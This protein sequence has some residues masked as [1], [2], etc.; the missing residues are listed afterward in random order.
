ME[1]ALSTHLP[2][3]QKMLHVSDACDRDILLSKLKF[4]G[5]SGKD[6]APYHSYLDNRLLK[7]QYTGCNRRNGPDF[8]RVFLMLNYT[9]KPQNTY[10]QI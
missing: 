3:L 5:I 7:Q 8:G 6:I 2:I 1:T 4:Y 10:I 9:E